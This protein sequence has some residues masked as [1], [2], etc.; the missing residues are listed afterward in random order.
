MFIAPARLHPRPGRLRGRG[1]FADAGATSGHEGNFAG[2][3]I[4]YKGWGH[5][6]RMI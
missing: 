6:W 4:F 3:A 5:E 2:M 1:G